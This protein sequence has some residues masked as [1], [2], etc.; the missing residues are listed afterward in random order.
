M[1]SKYFQ[2]WETYK[3][4]CDERAQPVR[5]NEGIYMKPVFERY[6]VEIKNFIITLLL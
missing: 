4:T 1:E 6:D 3:K 2:S 5:K